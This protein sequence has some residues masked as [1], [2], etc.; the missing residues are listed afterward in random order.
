MF[1][2]FLRNGD[3]IHNVSEWKLYCI[4]RLWPRRSVSDNHVSWFSYVFMISSFCWVLFTTRDPL[5]HC[6][7]R[8]FRIVT[9]LTL[10]NL[11]LDLWYYLL[12]HR[13]CIICP[14][15]TLHFLFLSLRNS[16][17]HIPPSLQTSPLFTPM[18]VLW[19][20]LRP[21]PISPSLLNHPLS[22][23]CFQS[24]FFLKK[25]KFFLS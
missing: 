20:A 13:K 3:E 5:L 25:K 4:S 22:S 24:L 8:W 21:T 14:A 6:P 16:D 2:Q 1:Y 9:V 15:G 11:T 10:N 17:S 18:H 23:R 7:K 19:A 12:I